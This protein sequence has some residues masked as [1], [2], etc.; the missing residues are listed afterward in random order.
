MVMNHTLRETSHSGLP[1]DV[2]QENLIT[3]KTDHFLEI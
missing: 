2:D 3:S 1:Y